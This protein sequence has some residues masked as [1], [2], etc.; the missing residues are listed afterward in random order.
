M[1]WLSFSYRDIKVLKYAIKGEG[2]HLCWS[3]LSQHIVKCAK[4]K[5][6]QVEITPFNK[7]TSD[8]ESLRKSKKKKKKKK[9][10]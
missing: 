7:I 3:P 2:V 10:S 5:I 8:D 9:K 1:M 6:I 4:S